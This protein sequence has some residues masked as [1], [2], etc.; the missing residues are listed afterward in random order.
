MTAT[1]SF[2]AGDLK[3][4]I[5]AQTAEVKAHP[6]DQDRR[7]FLFE[8]LAFSGDLDRARKQLDAIHYGDADL[9]LA[10]LSYRKLLDSEAARRKVFEA[11]DKPKFIG[12]VPRHAELRIEALE[13]R[14]QGLTAE[15][16]A[17]LV[18]AAEADPAVSGTLNGNPFA[19]FRDCDDF[20]G[21]LLEV[22]AQGASSGC[23]S[24]RSS[25]SGWPRPGSPAT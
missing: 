17:K 14:R 4:A 1:E 10:A 12:P 19:S 18:E 9:D 3:A 15:M 8:L 16:A 22:M 23:P 11:A 21:S 13:C 24:S 2:K 25:H 6:T 7:L 20:F 5:E